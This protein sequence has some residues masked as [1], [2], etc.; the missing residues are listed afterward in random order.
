MN[1][2]TGQETQKV[3]NKHVVVV[4][5]H[6]CEKETHKPGMAGFYP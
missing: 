3:F 1:A 5:I 6:R 4:V 2:I